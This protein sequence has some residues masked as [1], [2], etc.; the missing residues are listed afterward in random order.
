MIR[1]IAAI[2][3]LLAAAAP[4]AAQG[5]SDL[6]T[7]AP[8]AGNWTYVAAVDGSGAIFAGASGQPQLWV[9]CTRATR[10][11]TIAKAATVAAPVLNLWTSSLTRAVPAAFN[12]MTGRLTIELT[13]FDPL[14]DAIAFSRGRVGFATGAQSPL[15]LPPWPE[16]AR[17]I[18]DCRI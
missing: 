18:E 3:G 1:R 15:V 17:V 10:R 2:I 13:A 7:A 11:V 8:V 16:P 4:L 5:I 6:G 9:H 12:S 14:L